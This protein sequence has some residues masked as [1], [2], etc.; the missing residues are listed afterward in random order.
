MNG[1]G[2]LPRR[3]GWEAQ[4][5]EITIRRDELQPFALRVLIECLECIETKEPDA[6]ITR[7]RDWLAE[8]HGEVEQSE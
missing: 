4:L 3:V 1:S 8:D 7:L 2:D 5:D 6:R